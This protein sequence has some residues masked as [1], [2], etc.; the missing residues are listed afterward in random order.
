MKRKAD[1]ENIQPSS[2]TETEEVES[3]KKRVLKKQQK[4]LV[5]N[6]CDEPTIHTTYNALKKHESVMH[7]ERV[8]QDNE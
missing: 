6:Y 1:K 3:Q 4:N 8:K 2:E 5:C 7:R